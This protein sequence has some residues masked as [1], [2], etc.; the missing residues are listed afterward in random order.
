M[1]VDDVT[2]LRRD[3]GTAVRGRVH[4]PGDDTWDDARPAWNL[5]IDQ[6]P[7]AVV[8]VADADDVVAAVRFA[9]RA[10]LPVVAQSLGH[11]ATSDGVTD[12]LLLRMHA[13][14]AVEV[15]VDRRIA[16]VGGGAL[17]Q[18]VLDRLDGT[19]LLAL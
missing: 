10:G 7:S 15:D 3:L 8:E 14:D 11:A 12:A 2:G 17:W 5:A 4:L 19:G 1:T 18:A 9:K 16:R 6:R 13:L